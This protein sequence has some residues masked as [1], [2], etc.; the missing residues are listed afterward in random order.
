MPL[1]DGLH[2]YEVA[3]AVAGVL[4]FLVLLLLLARQVWTQRPYGGL[5]VFFAL[6]V[7]MIGWPSI[8]K[9]KIGADFISLE[10]DLATLQQNPKDATI[11]KNVAEQ[12]KKL[13]SRPISNTDIVATIAKAQ[14]ELG[15][16]TASEATVDKALAVAPHA[17]GL[18]E[19]KKRIQLNERL[20]DLTTIVE[21]NPANIE[22]KSE[23]Q[24]ASGLAP[25]VSTANP[26]F[27][28]TAAAAA[29]PIGHTSEAVALNSKAL[30]IDPTSTKGNQ[31][32][33]RIAI[34]Q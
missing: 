29:L 4:L 14:F 2:L 11:R 5:L 23:L 28:N 30:E 24:A 17:A 21:K 13:T 12:V 1:F 15:D 25:A 31:L 33:Q 10:K 27:L 18:L 9:V 26:E 6:P 8:Q 22:A 34:S 20:K 32:R 19:V 16:Q 7:I 3:L